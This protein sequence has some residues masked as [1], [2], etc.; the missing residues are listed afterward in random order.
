M[1]SELRYVSS[2]CATVRWGGRG[3]GRGNVPQTVE[4]DILIF[5]KILICEIRSVE[6]V[7]IMLKFDYKKKRESCEV[8]WS[9][10]NM[11][12]AKCT[13]VAASP[14]NR[15]WDW[16]I[17]RGKKLNW[18]KGKI[19]KIKTRG[20]TVRQG[21]YLEGVK[22]IKCSNQI[23]RVTIYVSFSSY[24]SDQRKAGENLAAHQD[25]PRHECQAGSWLIPLRRKTHE[26]K[27]M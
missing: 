5:V 19:K 23:S 10:H 26:H 16:K 12:G 21:Y 17:E 7:I 2:L 27:G 4:F 22:Y 6:I 25:E 9:C 8:D 15:A 13:S 11:I 18:V 24:F 14:T 20:G 1:V 3:R